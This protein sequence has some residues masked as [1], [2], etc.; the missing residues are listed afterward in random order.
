[1]ELRME[2]DE[3]VTRRLAAW[4]RAT[5]ATNAE[6]CAAVGISET[7]LLNRKRGRISWKLSEV[8]RLARRMGVTFDELLG[9]GQ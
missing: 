7:T 3:E 6:V 4:Q 9:I 5:G 1:M 8:G 2:L